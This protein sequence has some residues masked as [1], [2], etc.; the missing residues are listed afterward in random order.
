M[1]RTLT[2]FAVFA[3]MAFATTVA[4][5]AE[6]AIKNGE[7]LELEKLYFVNNC[8]SILKSPPSVELLSGPDNIS[9][10]VT[11]KQVLPR[12]QNCSK[13]VAG[14]TLSMSAKDISEISRGQVVLRVKYDTKDGVRYRS[15]SY[16][17]VLLP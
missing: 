11:P 15:Y 9:V 7:T 3:A 6:I 1:N 13:D 2:G 10:I 8:R 17:Y 5:A 16:D 4:Q 12:T 14:G